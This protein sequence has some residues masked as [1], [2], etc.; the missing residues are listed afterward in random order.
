MALTLSTSGITNSGT[1]QAAHVSQSIDALKGTHAY[2]LTPSGSF[3]FTGN[4]VFNGT[5]SGN[6]SNI[7]TQTVAETDTATFTVNGDS[8]SIY[9]LTVNADGNQGSNGIGYELPRP[10]GVTPGTT[11]KIIIGQIGSSETAPD[12]L[13]RAFSIFI[14]ASDQKLFGSIVTTNSTNNFSRS[15]GPFVQ[16]DIGSGR[17]SSGDQFDLICDGT[18][19]HVTGFINSPSVSYST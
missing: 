3:T 6:K 13:T 7:I 2:N 19:W 16:L 11:Y 1:I 18:Y 17:I 12:V 14:V 9:L 15:N 4:T 5:V 8:N 10:S